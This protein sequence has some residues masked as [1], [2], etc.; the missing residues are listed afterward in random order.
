MTDTGITIGKRT[1]I[2][3]ITSSTPIILTGFYYRDLW[4]K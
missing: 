2:V 1:G 3:N 4:I